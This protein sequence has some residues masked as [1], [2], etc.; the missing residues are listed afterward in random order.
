M[1]PLRQIESKVSAA[2]TILYK[3]AVAIRMNPEGFAGTPFP[4]EEPKAKNP[5]EGAILDYYFT[6]SPGGEVALEILDSQNK[7]VRRL[8]S[9]Q[10][11]PAG[12]RAGAIAD[13]WIGEPAR[14]TA[15]GGMNRYVWDL[16]L[17]ATEGDAAP[18]EFGAPARGPFVLPGSY[19]V[20]LTAG[21]LS[22]TQPLMVKL[23]PRSR[24][25]LEELSAQYSLSVNCTK[26]MTQ[27]ATAIREVQALRRALN[28]RRQSASA[29]LAQ[30]IAAFD[31]EAVKFSA[32]AAGPGRGGRGG[33]SGSGTLNAISA[34]FSAA[35][36][37]AQAAD[38][39]PP[40]GAYQIYDQASHELTAQLAAW[41]TLHD[42]ASAALE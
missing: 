18:N 25:S 15:N 26:G 1:T 6:S 32:G 8:S 39:K 2:T 10:T 17:G 31:A 20:R 29:D 3:P 41:R 21:G 22:Y 42:K 4:T 28:D 14:V 33:T 7:V 27:A 37:V 24:A 19:T 11:A 38:R 9:A 35:L 13:V 12:R 36:S 23:D 5:P 40:A 34:Q 30:K 16:R